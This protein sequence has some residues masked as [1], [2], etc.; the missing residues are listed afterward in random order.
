M[1]AQINETAAKSLVATTVRLPSNRVTIIKGFSKK[2][3]TSF[4]EVVRVVVDN[5]LAKYFGIIHYCDFEQGEEIQKR[6]IEMQNSLCKMQRDI[7]RIGVNYNQDIRLK[8]IERKYKNQGFDMNLLTLR[9]NETN[10]VMKECSSFSQQDFTDL[11]VR[12]E[13]AVAKLDETLSCIHS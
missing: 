7:A 6:I 8:Q 12:F 9:Q 10:D 3:H 5:R 2:Y 13:T 11:V 1:T 4:S